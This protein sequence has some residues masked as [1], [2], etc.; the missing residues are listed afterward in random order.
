[1]IITPQ[2]RRKEFVAPAPEV[3]NAYAR[4]ICATMAERYDPTFA[5]PEI[6]R[7][8]AEFLRVLIGAQIKQL[9]RGAVIDSDSD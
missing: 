4:T 8:F 9:N 3:I 5:H 7:G 1:M 6:M 2:K